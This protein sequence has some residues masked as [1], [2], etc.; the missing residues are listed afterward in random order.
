MTKKKISNLTPQ[1]N[2]SFEE[3]NLLDDDY[4][5]SEDKFPFHEPNHEK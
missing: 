4:N 1:K 2:S 5:H 3:E